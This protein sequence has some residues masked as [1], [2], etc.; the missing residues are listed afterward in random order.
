MQLLDDPFEDQVHPLATSH[1]KEALA[2]LCCQYE[3]D[4]PLHLRA[5]TLARFVSPSKHANCYWI[6][7]IANRVHHMQGISGL[8]CIMHGIKATGLEVLLRE[9]KLRAL[10]SMRTACQTV[11]LEVTRTSVQ[12]S[13]SKEFG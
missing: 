6:M 3:K 8:Q 2:E 7:Y 10:A 4:A 1:P 13:P 11:M 5:Q 12:A 9:G